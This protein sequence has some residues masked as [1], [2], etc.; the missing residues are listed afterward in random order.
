MNKYEY[1]DYVRYDAGWKSRRRKAQRL[2]PVCQCCGDKKFL[3]THHRTYLRVGHEKLSDLQVLCGEKNR[4]CHYVWHER[5]KGRLHIRPSYI[6]HRIGCVLH[7][8]YG[9]EQRREK[10]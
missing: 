9:I 10:K 1:Q 5:Q 8:Y 7:K 2:H 6:I 3:D 4:G